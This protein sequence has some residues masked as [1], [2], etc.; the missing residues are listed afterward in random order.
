M[1]F[2]NKCSVCNAAEKPIKL[3][4][5]KEK[6]TLIKNIYRGKVT[7]KKLPLDLFTRIYDA[8]NSSLQ[9][10]YG[11]KDV[12]VIKPMQE[13]LAHFSAAK[14]YQ[15]IKKCEEGRVTT[16]KKLISFDSY[17]KKTNPI[18]HDFLEPYQFA[19]SNHSEEVGK[20]TKKWTKDNK[21]KTVPY[22]EYV[23]MKDNR[24]RP[25]HILLDGIIR[26]STD[27]FWDTFYPPNGWMCRCR[28][29]ATPK[30]EET[31]LADFNEEDA[32]YNVPP[33]FRY[34]FAKEQIVFP[35]DHPY[36]TVPNA[37]KL[38]ARKNFN[39]PIPDGK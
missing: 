24:V 31:D 8:L 17:L 35:K 22:L 15:I 39:L 13:N 3:I 10:G 2:I 1:N 12:N 37:D 18:L 9:Y 27:P 26:K 6:E 32:L 14:T 28:T 29:N 11:D 36:F 33:S 4:S 20:A 38:F 19:E 25:A 7:K 5:D 16:D 34:N 23:T 30:G 21:R